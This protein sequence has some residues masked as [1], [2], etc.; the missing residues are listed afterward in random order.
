VSAYI[1]APATSLI[2]VGGNTAIPFKICAPYYRAGRKNCECITFPEEVTCGCGYIAI[3]S[4]SS[5]E[6][7]SRTIIISSQCP[8]SRGNQC[9][10]DTIYLR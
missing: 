2:F 5:P 9:T 6:R 1:I 4:Q 7:Y 8:D 3:P 10:G